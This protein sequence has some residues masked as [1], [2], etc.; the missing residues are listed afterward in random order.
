MNRDQVHISLKKKK[1][2]DNIATV[3]FPLLRAVAVTAI[4]IEEAAKIIL[5]HKLEVLTP[6]QVRSIRNERASLTNKK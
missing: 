5:R 1:K 4:L 6:L 2:K 3:W